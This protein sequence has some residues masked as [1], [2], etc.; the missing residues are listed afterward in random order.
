MLFDGQHREYYLD[1]DRSQFEFPASLVQGE[2][3]RVYSPVNVL[4]LTSRKFADL[5]FGRPAIVQAEGEAMSAAVDG[6]LKRSSL[7][8]LAHGLAADCS[9]DG[10][11]F[12]EA[13]VFD[14]QTYLQGV[15]A[16]EIF[17]VGEL[18]PDG[19]YAEYV[20]YAIRNAGT[21]EAPVWL[22][23]EVRYLAGRI[24]RMLCQLDNDGRISSRGLD[25][26]NWLDSSSASSAVLEPVTMTGIAANTITWIPNQLVRGEARSDY[27]GSPLKLQD[28]VNGRNTVLDN[29]IA[30]H[31]DPKLA[32]HRSNADESGNARAKQTVWW[33]DTLDQVPRY[34]TR[35]LQLEGMIT[36][37]KTAMGNLCL[38]LEMSP[39]I[40]GMQEG[41]QIDGWKRFKLNAQNALAKTSRKAAYWR[42]GLVR[43]I[44][45]A[46]DLELTL[47]G[48]RYDRVPVGVDI[49]DGLPDDPLD[50]ANEQATLRA[51]GLL[52][53]RRALLERLRDPAAVDVDLAELEAEQR[54]STPPV[55]LAEPSG[56]E[57]GEQRPEETP[58]APATPPE[59]QAEAV[60][61]T[62]LRST[63]GALN[64]VQT[65]QEKYYSGA[66][67][68]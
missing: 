48:V 62:D 16:A 63:V 23:L 27:D 49:Q 13:I 28:E 65:L 19:Q 31:G 42:S 15:D 18:Q 56:P 50:L 20:R 9:A 8:S 32:A 41:A 36:A 38:D 11:A 5:L 47:P 57:A 21:A 12:V 17:P 67:P 51:A 24:E 4:G 10:E 45:V 53:R 37:A 30:K 29:L 52:P 58:T 34:I 61:G 6:L 68:R 25:L 7:A 39:V 55:F 59:Q 35:D 22:M 14:G 43:A 54:A 2:V 3:W 46:L 44:E 1:E 26:A 33:F 66:L 40:L 60:A 64:A